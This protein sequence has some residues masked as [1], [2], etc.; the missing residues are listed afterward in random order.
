MSS[1]IFALCAIASI[2]VAFM[3]ARAYFKRPSRILLWSAI[4]FGGLALNNLIL[5]YDLVLLPEEI[6]YGVARNIVLSGSV[7]VLLYGLIWDTV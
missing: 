2:F 6:S 5:F 3:L 4:C 1:V 7:G